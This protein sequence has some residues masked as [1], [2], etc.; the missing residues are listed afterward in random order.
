MLEALQAVSSMQMG[1]Q[2]IT[3]NE[4]EP[5]SN[6]KVL[7]AMGRQDDICKSK[8]AFVFGPKNEAVKPSDIQRIVQF[9]SSDEFK[10]VFLIGFGFTPAAIDILEKMGT[11]QDVTIIPVC[12]SLDL[13]M[14]SVLKH[15]GTSQLFEILGIPRVRLHQKKIL[16]EGGNRRFSVEILGFNIFDPRSDVPFPVP[17]SHLAAWFL[18]TDHNDSL[19]NVKQAFIL[20]KGIWNQLRTRFRKKIQK[21]VW[22]KFGGTKSWPFKAGTHEKIAIKVI[23]TRGNEVELTKS[24]TD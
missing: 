20:Q 14:G 10:R 3:L 11:N 22:M 4:V 9:T 18:D 24:L 6:E 13:Q 16:Q 17:K 19:F 21:S 12:A 5:L 8:V 2:T 1:N 23:D 15:R 7:H